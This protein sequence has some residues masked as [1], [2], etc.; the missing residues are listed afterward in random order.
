MGRYG[1]LRLPNHVL[2]DYQG[3]MSRPKTV[4]PTSVDP[5]EE[6]L[7]I[8]KVLSKTGFSRSELYRQIA[9]GNFPRGRAYPGQKITFWLLSEV[10]AW[11]AQQLSRAA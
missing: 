9:A 7:R 2:R 6:F 3:T 4:D 10:R 1:I 11:Q 8:A 5:D